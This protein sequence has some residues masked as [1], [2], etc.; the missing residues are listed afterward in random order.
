MQ[1]S[2]KSIALST[3][4]KHSAKQYQQRLYPFKL[5]IPYGLKSTTVFIAR[6]WQFLRDYFYELAKWLTKVK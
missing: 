1:T 4:E 3:L 5:D 6:T 2:V